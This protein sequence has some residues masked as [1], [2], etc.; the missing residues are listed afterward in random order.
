MFFLLLIN[1]NLWDQKRLH[2][3]QSMSLI[4]VYTCVI[5]HC[6]ISKGLILSV[7]SKMSQKC[8]LLREV[9]NFFQGGKRGAPDLNKSLGG[10]NLTSCE[11]PKRGEKHNF[12]FSLYTLV[13]SSA[14]MNHKV[15]FSNKLPSRS[16]CS[17]LAD[18]FTIL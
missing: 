7:L 1:F 5:S 6:S 4:C 18:S 15:N 16:K 17:S 10:V 13:P 8:L 9:Q 14:C 2:H 3:K 12:S 11:T